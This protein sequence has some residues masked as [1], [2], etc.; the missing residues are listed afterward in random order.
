VKQ[1]FF[2]YTEQAE[3]YFYKITVESFVFYNS[4]LCGSPLPLAIAL[5][6]GQNLQLWKD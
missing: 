6:V 4:T 3:I 2:F 1:Y 5:M